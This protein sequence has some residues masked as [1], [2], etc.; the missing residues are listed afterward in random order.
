MVETAERYLPH[1]QGLKPRHGIWCHVA[2]IDLIRDR[3][4]TWHVLEDNL[5]VPSGI[6]YVV[7]NR[8]AMERVVPQLAGLV[9]PPE[10]YPLL[11]VDLPNLIVTPHIAWI[12]REARQ[13]LLDE[14]VLNIEAFKSGEVRNRV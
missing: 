7:K 5:R 6:A 9:P 12:S 1:C 8:Q 4:G 3:K 13:R 14:I 2:G 10:N 11:Q